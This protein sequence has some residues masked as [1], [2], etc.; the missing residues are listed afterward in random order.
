MYKR[1]QLP[2]FCLVGFLFLLFCFYSLLVC[3][4]Q[5]TGAESFEVNLQ[6][7]SLTAFW[8][9]VWPVWCSSQGRTALTSGAVTLK[10]LC[11]T[12]FEITYFGAHLSN[13]TQAFLY[14]CLI[15][16]CTVRFWDLCHKEVFLGQRSSKPVTRIS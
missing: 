6:P 14:K 1:W 7:A 11:Y 15:F 12:S 13:L 10:P 3:L 9:A 5:A 2:F 8:K 16:L 4:T